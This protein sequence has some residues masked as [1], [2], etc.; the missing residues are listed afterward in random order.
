M[1]NQNELTLEDGLAM[2]ELGYEFVIEDGRV[3]QIVEAR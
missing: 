3:T 2:H 1:G